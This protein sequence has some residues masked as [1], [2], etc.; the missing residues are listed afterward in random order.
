MLDPKAKGACCTVDT[1]LIFII[2]G[3]LLYVLRGVWCVVCGVVWCDVVWCGENR[4]LDSWTELEWVE[5]VAQR[6]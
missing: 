3:T 2:T 1:L 5:W 6:F 4:G